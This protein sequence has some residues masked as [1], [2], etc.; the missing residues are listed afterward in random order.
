MIDKGPERP[1]I[2]LVYCHNPV[3]SNGDCRNNARVYRDEEKIP[4]L[5]AV[6][7]VLSETT[8]LADLVLPDATYLERWTCDSRVSHDYIPEYFIRQPMHPPL[9]ES[10][11]F[12]DVACDIASRL[13]LELGFDSAEEFV[14]ATCDN[15]PGVKEAGGFEYMRTHGILCDRNA[16]VEEREHGVLNVKSDPLAE[17]G[18]DAIPAWM[19]IPTHEKMNADELILTTFKVNVHTHSRTQNCKWLTE[20]YHENPAWI[21]PETAAER[22]IENGDKI[23]IRSDVGE[24]I[25]RA[26]VT[27]GVHPRAIAISTHAGHWAYGEYAS[28]DKS[29]THIPEPDSRLR[30]WTGN[31]AHPNW[32]IPNLGDP[33]AGS[34]C[35]NDTVVRVTK[36]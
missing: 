4:F 32:V 31:G 12:C 13:G 10:R 29:K 5:V 30:W 15:T 25:S 20:I 36:A 28:G 24:I 21:H 11:N 9:G 16:T 17:A 33:I 2:Y 6:D 27:E 35:W 1:D 14:R 19:P 3:Y 18:F 7:I 34:M 26:L 22:G 8:E 23:R